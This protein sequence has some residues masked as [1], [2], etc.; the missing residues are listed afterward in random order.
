LG[1]SPPKAESADER[2]LPESEELGD[3][4]SDESDDPPE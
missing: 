3:P 2:A 4:E 1:E